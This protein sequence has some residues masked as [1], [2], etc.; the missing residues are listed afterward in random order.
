MKERKKETKVTNAENL[1][2]Y[3]FSHWLDKVFSL[4]QISQRTKLQNKHISFFR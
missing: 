1:K 4:P 3:I 2:V